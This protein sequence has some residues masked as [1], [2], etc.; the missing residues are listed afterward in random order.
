MSGDMI[1]LAI[2]VTAS[3]FL[4][5]RALRSHRLDFRKTAVMAGIWVVIIAVVA[6]VIQRFGT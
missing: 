4:A 2:T 5:L 6:F 3:L 1:V